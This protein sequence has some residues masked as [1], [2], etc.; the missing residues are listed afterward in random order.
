MGENEA[1]ESVRTEVERVRE[2]ISTLEDELDEAAEGAEVWED[3]ESSGGTA[4]A[5]QLWQLERSWERVPAL[6]ES[7][8]ALLTGD[9]SRVLGMVY[10]D[11]ARPDVTEPVPV[12]RRGG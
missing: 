3:I 10:T 7:V 12:P 11:V 2:Q 5:D 1:V 8:N 6:V 9:M 4:T